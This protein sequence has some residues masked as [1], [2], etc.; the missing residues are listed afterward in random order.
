MTAVAENTIGGTPWLVTFATDR[1]EEI[2]KPEGAL[3]LIPLA[4]N[5]TGGLAGR[6]ITAVPNCTPTP[7][8][9]C[10]ETHG[11]VGQMQIEQAPRHRERRR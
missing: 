4:L 2:P 9:D 3:V 7:T 6:V 11:F 5:D 8:L 10:Q 1:W